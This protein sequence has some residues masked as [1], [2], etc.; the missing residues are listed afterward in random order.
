MNKIMILLL[1]LLVMLGC[2][3]SKDTKISN[4]NTIE[5]SILL[6]MEPIWIIKSNNQFTVKGSKATFRNANLCFVNRK[7]FQTFQEL[8]N[9]Y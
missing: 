5:V 1:V 3:S 4:Q 2:S 7:K 8:E 9:N 6:Q